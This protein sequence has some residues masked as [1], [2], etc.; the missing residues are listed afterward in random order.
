MER[1]YVRPNGTLGDPDRDR[2]E[3]SAL[4]SH[5]MEST[6]TIKK[7]PSAR[8]SFLRA[9]AKGV[10]NSLSTLVTATTVAAFVFASDPQGTI[11]KV[12]T[13]LDFSTSENSGSQLAP[14]AS[15]RPTLRP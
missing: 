10:T 11:E 1:T 8:F 14:I 13:M 15:E 9:M 7:K 5:S 2:L 6:V 12:Q 3:A 4:K